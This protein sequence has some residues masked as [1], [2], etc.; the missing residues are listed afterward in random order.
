MKLYKYDGTTET[1]ISDLIKDEETDTG[2]TV[3]LL[4]IPITQ[5]NFKKGDVL[6]ARLK[7]DMD[8]GNDTIGV[9]PANRAGTNLTVTQSK[10]LVP[11]DLDL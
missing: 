3:F 10:I 6:R 4:Q 9:D 11:F 2:Q 5:T 8:N 7:C 1:A